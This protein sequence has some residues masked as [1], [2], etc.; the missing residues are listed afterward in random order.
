MIE[1]NS[2]ITITTHSEGGAFTYT[3]KVGAIDSG[4]N[5]DLEKIYDHTMPGMLMHPNQPFDAASP[6]TAV[7][8]LSPD[9]DSYWIDRRDQYRNVGFLI[10]E[11]EAWA[12]QDVESIKAHLS[13]D[14]SNG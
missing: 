5:L 13:K 8:D 11:A 10:D 3:A 4:G 12:T 9:Y 7:T 6:C 1:K 14:A 2:V